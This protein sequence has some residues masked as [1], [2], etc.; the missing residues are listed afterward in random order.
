LHGFESS[1]GSL[2]QNVISQADTSKVI[3]GSVHFQLL[4]WLE[5]A[6]LADA[7]ADQ[8]GNSPFLSRWPG[9]PRLPI[10]LCPSDSGPGTNNYAYCLGWRVYSF[11][12]FSS[13][14]SAFPG[15]GLPVRLADV[16]DGLS[17][18]AAASERL[19]GSWSTAKADPRRDLVYSGLEQVMS[20]REITAELQRDVC[21]ALSPGDYFW[22][23]TGESW[24]YVSFLGA[25]YNHTF[26]PNSDIPPCSIRQPILY[27]IGDGGTYGPDSGIFS[28]TSWHSGAVNLLLLDGSVR[29]V[30]DSIETSVWRAISTRAG[31][32]SGCH[33]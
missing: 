31:G 13:D 32:E 28:A 9:P 7:L 33:F 12:Y 19:M 22:P 29:T 5:Q 26:P 17:N 16:T 23:T 15:A 18:T 8:R 20:L 24:T 1:H 2:P 30:A 10:F 25:W 4:P 3:P 14:E 11:S 27:R 21:R 6:A